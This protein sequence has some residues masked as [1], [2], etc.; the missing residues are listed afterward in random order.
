MNENQ[1]IVE[2]SQPKV[3]LEE[4]KVTPRNFTAFVVGA[5]GRD[6]SYNFFTTYLL[7]F[8]LFSKTLTDLQFSCVSIIII[9]ARIFDAFND[10][11]MGG[12]I[13]NTNTRWGKFRPWITIGAV[14]TSVVVILIF[15]VPVDGWGFI[16]FLAIMYLIY[17]ITFTMN[18]IAYWGLLPALG[19]RDHDRNRLMSIESVIGGAGSGLVGLV[20]PAL[21]TTYSKYLGGSA[22]SA[23]MWTAVFAGVVMIA[24]Q[25]FTSLM[26]KEKAP[27]VNVPKKQA[28]KLSI[29]DIFRII[30][31]NDQLLWAT[32]I[33]SLYSIGTGVLSGGLSTI[34]IYFEF[35]YNGLLTTI[36]YVLGGVM[37][38]LFTITFPYILQKV[39]RENIMYFGGIVAICAYL[40]MMFIGVFVPT[41]L[42]IAE[43]MGL[44]IYVK[45]ILLCISHMFVGIGTCCF[46]TLAFLNI[47]N[48]VEYNE[49]KTGEREESLIFSLR[50][51]SAKLSSALTQ[52]LVTLVY[53][54]IG[55]TH[56]TNGI[57]SLD[58]AVTKGEITNAEM[59]SGVETLLSGVPIAQ[60]NAL[61]VCMC[62]IPIVF[63]VVAL[64]LLKKKFILTTDYFNKIKQDIL[65][66]KSANLDDALATEN[67]DS[68]VE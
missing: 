25:L 11:I 26:L 49:W 43:I 45:F 31:S 60:K 18:D 29:K 59:L 15:S 10:P 54:A 16:G 58:Q 20:V 44:P 52:L 12:I 14:A 64:I 5:F 47:A 50:P 8:I 27:M 51:F 19:R 7:T 21:T 61:I 3:A 24:F 17:S 63:L 56:V 41:G 62:L 28:P 42:P 1:A 55:V 38:I 13:E 65:D 23:Y 34:Y 57:S 22:T 30:K 33:L 32:V 4:E 68:D 39:K 40:I 46:Y 37:N 36:F 35:G 48:T 9:G 2:N 6:F 66:R 53:L 67:L